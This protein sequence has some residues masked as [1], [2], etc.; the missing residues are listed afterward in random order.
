[1]EEGTTSEALKSIGVRDGNIYWRK[2]KIGYIMM[3]HPEMD[4]ETLKSVP[5]LLEHPEA[6]LKSLTR[7]DSIVVLGDLRAANGDPVMAALELTPRRGGGMEAEFSLISSA[8]S[9]T[10]KS[11]RN[12][13]N[14]SE[15]L[16]LNPDK[17]E[18]DTWLMQLRVQFPS[19]Q[20]VYGSIGSIT[21]GDGAVKVSGKTLAELGGT[22]LPENGAQFSMK[23]AGGKPV[24]WIENG[25]LTNKEL[26]SHKAVAEFIAQH[27]GEV[28]TIIESGQ[29]VYIG[30]DLPGEYTQSRYTSYL[31][32]HARAAMRAKNK[33]IDGLGEL[34]ETATNRRLEKTRHTHSKDAK[35]GMY[36]HDSTFAFPVKEQDGTVKR[37]QAY[38]V[39]LLIRNASDGKK[40]LYDIVNIKENTSAQID[41][42]ARE[43]RSAAYKAATGGDVSES[44]IPETDGDVNAGQPGEQFSLK[45]TAQLQRQVK[46][47]QER[48]AELKE[49]LR[50]TKGVRTDQKKTAAYAREI[51]SAYESEYDS[52]RLTDELLGIYDEFARAGSGVDLDALRSRAEDVAGRMLEQSVRENRETYEEYGR[53]R[54]YLRKTKIRVPRSL[55]S[56]FEQFGGYNNFRK[57]NMGRLSLSSTDGMSV[58]S[59]YRELSEQYPELFDE[60]EYANP[61]DQLIN[62][63]DVLESI[64][65]VVENPYS[66]DMDTAS[67]FVASEILEAYFDIPQQAPTFA[68]RQKAKLEAERAKGNRRLAQEREKN[69]ERLAQLR[70]E[71][72]EQARAAIRRERA[73]REERL[74]ALREKYAARDAAGR[75]RRSA[76]ELRSKIQRHIKALSQKL[77]SN[78]DKKHILGVGG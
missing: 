3:E 52:E 21:Y 2:Q 58:D 43:A 77:T 75:E 76:R 15:I 26:N 65:P 4:V 19:R 50:T 40:Y 31:R 57:G 70:E 25:S 7:E 27:I 28:Y 38:D 62:L 37:V 44:S 22:V 49:Q 53:L 35:Y 1:M 14:R 13:I 42:S 9:R 48:N 63:S 5:N 11:I 33:A 45:G 6:V 56:E 24:V 51:L 18:A 39:E 32:N 54:D 68:D 61:A 17:K 59:V 10:E 36:R 23:T 47:L 71:G 60:A 34:I 66:A 16:Y 30:P 55:W 8:Y 78:T 73:K 46:N 64:Q 67:R 12:M 41:L 29:K 74:S 72:R 20:P 69:R